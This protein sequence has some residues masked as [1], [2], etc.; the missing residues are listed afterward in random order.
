MRTINRNSKGLGNGRGRIA[1]GPVSAD[2]VAGLFEAGFL[3][4]DDHP[5]CHG[6][7]EEIPYFANQER[8]SFA[9]VGVINPLD[10]R[11]YEV[12]GGLAGLRL[13]LELSPANESG[14]A[15][16]YHGSGGI[17]PLRAA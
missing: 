14:G 9:R 10:L 4:G 1:Y 12:H 16:T 3:H 11:A 8:L 2:D 7:T 15:K 6:L 5:L 13:A 17:V